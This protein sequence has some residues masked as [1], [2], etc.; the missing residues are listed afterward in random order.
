M[1]TTTAAA[2]R[3]F[4]ARLEL[5]ESQEST[6][7]SRRQSVH[8]YLLRSCG[9][10]STMPLD[11]T[12]VIGSIQRRTVIRPLDDVDVLAVFNN[13]SNAYDGYRYDSRRFLYRVRDALN[14]FNIQ[15]VGSRGQ[16]VRIFYTTAPYVDVVPAFALDT[17]GFFIPSGSGTWITTDPDKHARWMTERNAALSNQLRPLVRMLKCWNRAHS[18]RM[19]S[20]HLEVLA[21]SRFTSLGSNHREATQMFFQAAAGNPIVFDPAGHSGDLSSYLGLFSRQ[22]LTS[23]LYNSASR[24]AQA[25]AAEGATDHAEAIRLWR[26][27]F[28]S[29]F[30]VYG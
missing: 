6:V 2:F 9:S 8:N 17:G 25:I 16:A 11:R 12:Q 26:I 24:A 10:D 14:D 22:E 7:V 29:D 5:T 13:E 23:L 4:A 21:A 19:R 15:V 18:S 1:A 3:E 27:I 28:G 20:F 30:P